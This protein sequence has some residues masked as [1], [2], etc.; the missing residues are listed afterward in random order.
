MREVLIEG[1]LVQ[2]SK[3]VLKILDLVDLHDRTY[4]ELLLL[5]NLFICVRVIAVSL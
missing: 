4:I 3:L 2:P 5:S 1:I